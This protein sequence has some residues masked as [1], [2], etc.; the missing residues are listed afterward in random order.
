MVWSER[1][2]AVADSIAKREAQRNA[3]LAERAKL[4]IDRKKRGHKAP[5]PKHGNLPTRPGREGGGGGGKK[6]SKDKSSGGGGSG[7]KGKGKAKESRPGFE[8]KRRKLL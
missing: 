5:K 1:K 4:K 3:R 6:K 7:K 2:Q 8:G